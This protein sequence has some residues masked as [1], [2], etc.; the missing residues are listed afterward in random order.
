V[1]V[2]KM[3]DTITYRAHSASRGA[4]EH[5]YRGRATDPRQLVSR[6]A[7]REEGGRN[8]RPRFRRAQ[9]LWALALGLLV[10]GC[11]PTTRVSVSYQPPLL[12]VAFSIDSS[13]AVSVSLSGK[14]DT[15][16]GLIGVSARLS[17][18]LVPPSNAT[19]VAIETEK[20][21][22]T[23]RTMYRIDATGVLRVCTTGNTV[24]SI[25]HDLIQ[26][27]N[28]GGGTITVGCQPQGGPP[29][30]ADTLVTSDF[31]P[32]G[33]SHGRFDVSGTGSELSVGS[34]GG[35]GE[36]AAL[37]GVYLPRTSCFSSVSFY[38]QVIP[39]SGSSPG[40]GYAIGLG[41]SVLNDQPDGG[42][43]QIEWDGGL[44]GFF[45]RSVDLP[46]GAWRGGGSVPGTDITNSHH[47]VVNRHAS[48]YLVTIDGQPAGSFSSPSC[49]NLIF[50]VWG[51]ATA[52]FSQLSASS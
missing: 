32:F 33:E 17:D 47:V 16:V 7:N 18:P 12:P 38:A 4:W 6:R 20:D 36:Y 14:V 31:S 13:G 39:P 8:M 42:S 40:Y 44:G 34:P 19:L 25:A 28:S 3:A 26:V 37:W 41:D 50:R 5:P 11:G 35:P 49:G 45:T 46:A 21:G 48:G 43:L 23:Q 52:N 22:Q 30:S 2:T 15:P 27:A 24:V 10:A 51:G 29:S 1:I 9:G